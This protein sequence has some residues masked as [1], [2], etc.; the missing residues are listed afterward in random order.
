MRFT[1][2]GKLFPG[3]PLPQSVAGIEVAKFALV[4]DGVHGQGARL[5]FV[6]VQDRAVQRGDVAVFGAVMG[7]QPVAVRGG[8]AVDRGRAL[9][10]R[11]NLAPGLIGPL[12]GEGG[13]EAGLGGHAASRP[14]AVAR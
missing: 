3:A 7:F 2:G 6:I 8:E 11:A 12:P 1:P 10:V 14:W 5:L 4:L 13:G 9:A